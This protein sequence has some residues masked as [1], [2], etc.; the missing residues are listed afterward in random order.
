MVSEF[1]DND[2]SPINILFSQ[3]FIDKYKTMY[4]S[5]KKYKAMGSIDA[6][7]YILTT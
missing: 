2:T 4:E 5:V 7:S 6:I 1:V 3:D